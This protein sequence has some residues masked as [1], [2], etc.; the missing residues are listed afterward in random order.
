MN[1]LQIGALITVGFF[2][3]SVLFGVKGFYNSFGGGR[4]SGESL[5]AIALICY[6]GFVI[7]GLAT[8][9]ILLGEIGS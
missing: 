8:V 4:M 9:F 6:G 3:L 2:V 1:A 5:S 7:S